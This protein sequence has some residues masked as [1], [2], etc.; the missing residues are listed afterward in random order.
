MRIHLLAPPARRLSL[1]ALVALF[2]L[3]PARAETFPDE[4]G[5]VVIDARNRLP[6]PQPLPFPVGGSSPDGHT[7]SAN[8]RY[9]V[10]DG[11]PWFP[12]M[13]EFHYS[14]YPAGK[15][16]QEILK[17][18]AGGIQVLSTYVFWIHHEEVEGQFDWSG[19]RNLRGFVEL[20]SRHGMYVWIRIGPWA[21]GEVRNGG[22]P[23]WLLEKTATREN[24]PRYLDY[25]A[26]FYGEI[27]KQ[28]KGLLWKDGGPIVGIQLENEYSARGP[29]KGA[30]HILR[31]RGL[32][33]DAGLDV[34]FYTITGWDGA[35][36]PS[37][38]VLPVFSGYADGF[39]WRTLGELPPNPNYFFTKIRCQENVRE[40]L[41]SLHPEID[42]LDGKYPFLTA[43]MGGGMELAY[44][45]RP[46]VAAEDT[47]A[48]ELVKLGSGVT[49]YG[50]YMF[51]GGTNPD[52]KRTTLEESTQTG[53]PNDVPV[54][55][56]DF[57]AP[58]GEFGQ[59]RRSFALLKMLHLFLNDFG[60]E[61]A[62]M[63]PF[64]SAQQPASLDDVSTPRVA[65][66]VDGD[67]GFVFISN[68]Q[69]NYPLP[70]HRNFQ[71][72]LDL[73]SGEITIPRRPLTI[74]KDTYTFWPVNLRL[75]R[76]RLRYS[77]A[78]LL[79]KLDN[80]TTYV[81]FAPRGVPA[82]FALEYSGG[83]GIRAPRAH[84]DRAGGIAYVD[85][86]RPGAQVAIEFERSEHVEANIVV[87]SEEQAEHLWK[88]TLAGRERLVLS[89][90]QLYAERGALVL[91]ASDPREFGAGVF[92][93]VEGS[94]PEFRDGVKNG[95]FRMY[96][97]SVQP[98]NLTARV[99]KRSGPGIEPPLKLGKETLLMPDESAFDSAA[100]WGV[101]VP[102]VASDAISDVLLKITY[103]GDIARIYAGGKLVTDNFYY[104]EP[105]T[106]GLGSIPADLLRG[107]LELRI[108]PLRADSP[109]YLPR[110]V[111]PAV[112]PER[113]VAELGD[114][115]IVPIYRA[116]LRVGP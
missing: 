51:H 1:G 74:P 102:G 116:T 82:E 66:R 25:V 55:S 59:A 107:P 69:R 9:L 109:I 103:R 52:G 64:F 68:Y 58:L 115:K 16:E 88:L 13:G 99:E 60:S 65:A 72:R 62:A 95:I 106:V 63:P 5:P 110:A 24:N 70:E 67:Q 86:I 85:G 15:W 92:P 14:R 36:I 75:G 104:G 22:L 23:D 94:L 40:D 31:L 53:Y 6:P 33:R 8:Q 96:R 76:T 80:P 71:V 89:S 10:R 2:L 38:G 7:L 27:G 108:L 21:H 73:P 77:T 91:L 32:A 48:M 81:F 98:V 100:A 18:K 46:L 37:Q 47:A 54:K 114:V 44:H 111:Y 61:L 56:Y 90:A 87:L 101:E 12:I 83:A 50:Y 49:M 93:A 26:R 29:G 17:M 19:Q 43:E 57:Q 30:E 112:P 39:W 20:A 42:M 35:V 113:P 78:Q 3:W 41:T 105:L 28:V 4:R 79:C 34:P 97:A 45:R 11:K 84:I